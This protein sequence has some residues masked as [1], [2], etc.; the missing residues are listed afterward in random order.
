MIADI[1][2]IGLRIP[3]TKENKTGLSRMIS[4]DVVHKTAMDTF[5]AIDRKAG[6]KDVYLGV[7]YEKPSKKNA[8]LTGQFKVK[9]SDA[10][11]KNYQQ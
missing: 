7:K 3:K 11:G 1:N 8:A 6:C 2:F 5:E 9:I 10:D 4:N